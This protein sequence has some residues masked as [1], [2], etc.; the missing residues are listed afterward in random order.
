M[1]SNFSTPKKSSPLSTTTTRSANILLNAPR[2]KLLTI[3]EKNEFR[4]AEVDEEAKCDYLR[5]ETLLHSNSLYFPNRVQISRH[6]HD[7]YHMG[8][9][10]V[11]KYNPQTMLFDAEFIAGDAKML[12][13]SEYLRWKIM[14][15]FES[16]D[17]F[18]HL[19]HAYT[20][21]IMACYNLNM[22][23]EN[24]KAIQEYREQNR[25]GLL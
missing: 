20:Q 1:T 6:L 25:S 4:K 5:F 2:K 13:Y 10:S 3:T 19:L 18:L 7:R 8:R 22:H 15:G 11:F 23:L 16:E 12:K 24:G 21:Y 17:E 9:H 14:N